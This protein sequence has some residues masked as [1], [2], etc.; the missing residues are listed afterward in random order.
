M[1]DIC[2]DV[3]HIQDA[4][5]TTWSKRGAAVRGQS[6]PLFHRWLALAASCWLTAL[7]APAQSFNVLYT[8]SGVDNNAV[9][10]YPFSLMLSSNRT[11]YGTCVNGGANQWGAIYKM[12]PAGTPSAVYS[13]T[14]GTDGGDPHAGLTQGTNGLFYGMAQIG[15]TNG[16]G[17]IFDVST[18]GTCAGLYSFA[19]EKGVHLT[20]ANGANPIYPLALNT[21]N[22]NFY[23]TVTDAG[24]NGYGTVFQ[25]THQGKVT[26]FYSFS[27][28]V[29]G[30]AP[31]GPLMLYTNGI[32][33]GT[34]AGGGSNGDGTVFQVTAAG[35]VTSFYSFTNG[36]DGANPQGALIDGKDGHLY[37][38]CAAGGTNGSGTIFKI[39]TNGVLTPLYSFSPGTNFSGDPA[40]PEYEYNADGINPN[41]LV[42]GSDGNFYGLAYYGGQN[43]SGSV[44]QF[45]RSGTLNVLHSFNYAQGQPN[46]DGANPTS[47]LQ[48]TNGNFY[49]TAKDGGANGTG[50]FFTI[51]LPPGITTQPASQSIALHGNASF[52]LTASN[53]QSCQWQFNGNNLPNATNYTLSITNAHMT[54]AGSYQAI[55]T[56]LNGPTPSSVVTLNLT[57]VPVS[58]VSGPGAVQYSGGQFS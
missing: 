5:M 3:C 2:A 58:F 40:D 30:A 28:M 55:V 20:N 12:T 56:N 53:A 4:M 47:L 24:T 54:N 50:T 25:I 19:N 45:T 11:L 46:A 34:A 26:V 7:A 31:E 10:G 16:Y 33:Y 17:A 51:G 41:V 49:G 32:L 8:F 6:R 43:G 37:G 27:N 23:G 48:F 39:T 29:D 14:D 1:Q 38:T 13:F 36:S 44:F 52:S 9:G 35:K 57:N 18:S 21:N 15:G 42:L 22:N